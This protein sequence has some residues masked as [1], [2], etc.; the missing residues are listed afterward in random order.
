MRHG[1]VTKSKIDRTALSLFVRKGV[2]ETTIRDIAGGAG[3]AEGTIYRHYESKEALV[4]TL[5]LENY[6]G[7]AGTLREL[8]RGQV[9][10]K[11]K[12][13]AMVEG[14]CRFYDADWELFTFLLITQ[15]QA[16]RKLDPISGDPVSVLQ[17]VI[18]AGQ[19]RGELP[20]R[21]PQ[22]ATAL[23]L[24]VVLQPAT[25]RVYGRIREPLSQLSGALAAAVWRVVGLPDEIIGAEPA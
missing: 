6:V 22:L 1:H 13:Q 20:A 21:D 23:L 24:G 19:A 18:E 3:I 7:F 12:I 14:F 5:F 25:F 16:L 17:G 10:V 4:Q 11:D 8:E 9:H 15:H 2:A